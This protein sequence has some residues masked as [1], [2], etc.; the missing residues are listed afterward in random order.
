MPPSLL[1][2]GEELARINE[3]LHDIAG[4][5]GVLIFRGEAG[6]GKTA[7]LEAAA[8]LARGLG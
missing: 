6:T 5:G 4:R 7:L 1:A 2:R 8:A 3:G